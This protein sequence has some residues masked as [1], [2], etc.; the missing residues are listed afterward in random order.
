MS[1]CVLVCVGVCV[2]V[3]GCVGVCV[4]GGDCVCVGVCL[5]LGGI[6]QRDILTIGQSERERYKLVV[7]CQ[8]TLSFGTLLWQMKNKIV[9]SQKK[10]GY[11]LK[12]FVGFFL[13]F[14]K[15]SFSQTKLK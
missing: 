13:T 2:C 3:C 6:I 10:L 8:Y 14:K 11:F 7:Q 15:K 5:N 12:S 1:L 4:W 9:C